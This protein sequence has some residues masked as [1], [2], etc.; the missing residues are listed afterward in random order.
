MAKSSPR[1]QTG[2]VASIKAKDIE[3]EPV[4]NVLLALTGKI[5]GL[6]ITQANGLAGGGIKVRLQGENSF[7]NNT[8]P[9]ISLMEF[10][11]LLR[12]HRL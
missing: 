9:F 6:F 4:N 1:F 11:T 10:L 8:G 3:K 12:F 2:N 5:P 7:N